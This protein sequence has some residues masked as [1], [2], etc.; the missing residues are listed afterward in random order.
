METSTPTEH[1][2]VFFDPTRRRGV[3]VQRVLVALVLFVLGTLGVFWISV[4]AVPVARRVSILPLHFMPDSALRTVQGI[5]RRLA[6]KPAP[7]AKTVWTRSGAR[8]D[9]AWH[10]ISASPPSALPGAGKADGVVGGFY[11]SWDSA[12]LA[13]LRQH[14]GEMTH[15]FPGWLHLNEDG[16]RLIAKDSDPSDWQAI[17]IARQNHLVIVP[18]LNNFS[19]GLQDFDEQRLHDLL[20]SPALRAHLIGEIRDYLVKRHYGGINVDLETEN[21]D[22]RALLPGFAA[23]M[24]ATLQPLGLLMTEDTQ[25]GDTGQ[26]AA[27]ARACDFVIPMIYDLHYAN[28]GDPG[29]IAPDAWA[30]TQLDDYLKVVP[31]SKTVLAIGNYAYDWIKKQPGAK[32]KTFGEA[33]ATAQESLDGADGVVHFDPASKNPYFSYTEDDGKDHVVWFL[34]AVTAYNFQRYAASRGVKGRALWYVG[35]ED[36][37][38]WSFFGRGRSAATPPDLS[39][40]RYGFEI[41]PEGDG[42]ILDIAAHPHPGY[43]ATR[44]GPDG[45]FSD[46]RFTSYPTVYIVRRTGQHRDKAGHLEKKLALTFDDGPDPRWTPMILDALKESGAPGTFFVIGVNAQKNPGLLQREWAEGSEIGNHSFYHPNMSQTSDARSAIEIDATQRTIQSAIGRSTALFRPPFGIDVEPATSDE[47]RPV[48]IAQSKGYVTVAEG[49]DPRDWETGAKKHT[50]EEIADNIVQG[51]LRG[52]GNVVLLHDGGGDRAETARALPLAISRL[53]AKGFRF[54][55]VT[56]LIGDKPR[57]SYFP[58]VTGRQRV[59]TLIDR[60]IFGFTTITG[61]ALVTLFLFTLLAGTLRLLAVGVLAVLHARREKTRE[62][63]MGPLTDSFAPS[64][65][66][67]I[68]AYNEEKVIVRTIRALLDGGYPRLEVIVVDD[69][70]KDATAAVVETAFP[71]DPRVRVLR[72]ANGGKAAALNFGIEQSS[73]EILVGLDADTLF[74]PDT[75]AR[76]CRH[77]VDPRVGAVAGNVQVGNRR[78]LL[79]RWQSVEYITSQNFDRRAYEMLNAI[80]VIPGA[81]SAWRMAAVREAGGY[82]TDTLAEDADL[83]WR[84]RRMGWKLQTDSTAYA[85]TEAPERLR[86]LVKQR[87]RWTFGTLQTLYKHRDLLFRTDEGALGWLVAP[88]LWLFQIILPLALPFADMGLLFA[89]FLGNLAAALAYFLFFFVVEFGAACLAFHLDHTPLDKR[90]D[91]GWL[92]LQRLVYRYL[93]F[94]VLVSALATAV[95]G[96]RAG[97]NKLERRGTA[98]VGAAS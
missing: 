86:E 30:R 50:A 21:E 31:A 61:T 7:P 17:Q 46:E 81:V 60:E 35:S 6:G 25:V 87:F 40:V 41:T 36:P 2:P 51:A 47:L 63:E 12:S 18:L 45:Y 44:T 58:L 24:A 90:R 89:A 59:L 66:V 84:V 73:G 28:G 48:D 57:D 93:L 54:V 10:G 3:R 8:R 72:K 80:P 37:T 78:N 53:R 65:T 98:Q 85:Y 19:D 13:S 34:D 38:L 96:S 9:A 75:V 20:I 64:V 56:D 15:L 32:T 79:T 39:T 94:Y 69:G 4:L 68:A 33:M 62:V 83:T 14:A 91:I 26:A 97:W 23:E 67:V 16:S 43:R 42:E 52:D 29:P 27:I 88:S 92:F 22:D 5:G 95:R 55:T 70:S 1:K 49:I 71:D 74:A 11:V 77:F 82:S 76:L